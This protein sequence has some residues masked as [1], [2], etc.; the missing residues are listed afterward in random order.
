MQDRDQNVDSSIAVV[1][2]IIA[3]SPPL[4]VE[5]FDMQLFK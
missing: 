2:A 1:I 3:A 4:Q 5:T